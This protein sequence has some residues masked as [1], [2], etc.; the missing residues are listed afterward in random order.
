MC[1]TVSEDVSLQAK[2]KVAHFLFFFLFSFF[3]LPFNYI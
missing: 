1:S 2:N 3:F